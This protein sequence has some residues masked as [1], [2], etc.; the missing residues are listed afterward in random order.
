MENFT[1]ENQ[2]EKNNNPLR[3]WIKLLVLFFGLSLVSSIFI[4]MDKQYCE[5][6]DTSTDGTAIFKSV[7]KDNIVGWVKVRGIIMED[8]GSG[9]SSTNSASTLA[10]RIKKLGEDDDIKAIVVDIDSPGGT[11]ASVQ[12]IYDAINFVR[13]EH[14]KPVIALFRDV[15]A[16]GGYY[17]AMA[18]DKI[19]A[20]PGTITGSIGVIM[21]TTNM[22]ELFAK[23]GVKVEPI[24]SGEYKDIGS[25]YREMT[26]AEKQL[27][28]AMIDDSYDQFYEVVKN[29]RQLTDNVL[30]NYADG[31]VF[32][33]R[34]ALDIKMIDYLGGEDKA[35]AIAE[36]LTG[37]EDLKIGTQKPTNFKDFFLMLDYATSNK[38]PITKSIE[39]LTTPKVLYLWTY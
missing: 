30:R 5:V 14:K 8:T 18:C 15:A 19:I 2:N 16:S 35:K 11:V 23:I 29:N 10:N 37:I 36:E 13:I 1:P 31:R 3:K 4:I 39:T 25:P 38:N 22:Q 32:T 24:K 17:I 9:W 21:Q 34:Q 26:P 33:G 20:Q 7:K 6:S 27:I 12:D 28:Q